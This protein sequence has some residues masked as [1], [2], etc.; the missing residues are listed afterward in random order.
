MNLQEFHAYQNEDG[1]YR[2]EAPTKVCYGDTS[3][4]GKLIISRAKLNI[5]CLAAQD[6]K[7]MMTFIAEDT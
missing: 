4:N 2:I 7:D 6:T 5:E 1:T 3:Y